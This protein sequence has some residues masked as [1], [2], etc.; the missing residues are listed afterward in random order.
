MVD[1]I[2]F[3]F[4]HMEV[5]HTFVGQPSVLTPAAGEEVSRLLTSAGAATLVPLLRDRLS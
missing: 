5:V 1:D 4:L 3:E 2:L